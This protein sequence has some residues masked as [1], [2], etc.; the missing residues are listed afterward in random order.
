MR[1]AGNCSGDSILA[2]TPT[3]KRKIGKS[4][5]CYSTNVSALETVFKM[6]K[7]LFSSEFAKFPRVEDKCPGQGI[8][9]SVGKITRPG[10]LTP[11]CLKK[12]ATSKYWNY[13][14][15]LYNGKFY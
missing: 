4:R 15:D 14:N 6:I 5:Y 13:S 2:P 3:R 1:L 7:Y 9:I 11:F 10:Y 12:I 8:F